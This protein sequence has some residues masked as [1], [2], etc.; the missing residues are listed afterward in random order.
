M[1]PSA[2]LENKSPEVAC[3]FVSAY[4]M[5]ERMSGSLRA[6]IRLSATGERSI[7]VP[8]RHRNEVSIIYL[9]STSICANST[10]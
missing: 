8:A 9:I 1:E 10:C 2:L 7:S 5:Q 6:L 3:S 4:R